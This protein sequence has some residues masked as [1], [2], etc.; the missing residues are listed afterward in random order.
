MK[1]VFLSVGLGVVL[2]IPGVW[3]IADV[4]EGA[5]IGATCRLARCT[6]MNGEGLLHEFMDRAFQPSMSGAGKC[7]SFTLAS[8]IEDSSLT[9]DAEFPLCIEDVN[10]GLL[11]VRVED[12]RSWSS[13][14]LP[15]FLH[16]AQRGE[17]V[18]GNES[19]VSQTGSSLTL[20]R[21]QDC[22][23]SQHQEQYYASFWSR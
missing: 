8:E 3:A 19:I 18:V 1:R 5:T 6:Q 16:G 22:P 7:F 17:N 14:E 21:I 12:E 2:G 23:S 13:V 15:A 20:V 11:A 9:M 4:I 10:V